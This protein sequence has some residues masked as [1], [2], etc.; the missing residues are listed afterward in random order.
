MGSRREIAE[1]H[2]AD[3]A[4]RTSRDGWDADCTCPPPVGDVAGMNPEAERRAISHAVQACPLF[5]PSSHKN[6]YARTT[7]AMAICTQCGKPQHQ[8]W[9]RQL[10]SERVRVFAKREQPLLA[11][12]AR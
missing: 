9:L 2:H 11:G 12:D 4:I 7:G 10:L 1:D 3:C 5:T 6:A 8:H